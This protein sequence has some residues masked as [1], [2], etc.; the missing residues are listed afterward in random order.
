[1]L[2]IV[3]P[4][5]DNDL[6]DLER[7]K[8]ELGIDE[9]D[10]AQ[11]DKLAAM[12]TEASSLIAAYCNRDAFGVEEL[13][14]TER[15]TCPR[16]YILLARDLGVQIDAVTVDGTALTA[17][18]YE[19]DGALLYRLDDDGRICWSGKVVVS[20]VAGYLIPLEAPTALARAALDLVVNLY[21]GAGRDTSIR[22]EMVEGVGSTSYTDLRANA[23]LP[24]SAERIRALERYR[25]V[26]V[27]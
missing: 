24:L 25:L 21:R 10:T 23:G 17:G 5:T 27:G 22:Q 16:A 7:V 20:Y 15:I 18:D 2:E 8:T 3:T 6:V 26:L 14:Q 9:G 19:L 13:R 4:S 1:M 12:I 11:D